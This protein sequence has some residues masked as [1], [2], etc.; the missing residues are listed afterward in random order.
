[1]DEQIIE[2]LSY[3]DI[4][5]YPVTLSELKRYLGCEITVSDDEIK[6]II[7]EIP[8]IQESNGYY[9]FLGRQGIVEK[10]VERNTISIAKFVKA[11]VIAKILSYIPTIEYIG[12]SGSLSMMN[13]IDGD[14]ID[15]F[16]ITRKNTLW[17]TRFAVNV[18]LILMKQKRDR[19]QKKVKDKICPNM[20]MQNGKLAFTDK[21][22]TL[23]I[24][25]E[26]LQLKTLYDKSD[27]FYRLLSHNRWVSNFFPNFTIPLKAST[28]IKANKRA[29]VQV[30]FIIML[31]K[32][33]FNLQSVYMK[34]YKTKEIISRGQAFFH[35]VDKQGMILSM[36]KLKYKRYKR[37]FVDNIWIDRDEARFYMGE[38]KIRTLN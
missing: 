7:E 26:I 38:K 11:K 35:P 25:H 6:E 16:F 24:A 4:F 21:R 36:H 20:F 32:I 10:R 37:L 1:M 14:D 28:K 18:I 2:T 17:I 8:I 29:K 12:I 33:F 30:K 15:L 13:A 5:D 23:Y 22:K 19:D 3:F 27:S 9:Y 34:N 31:E